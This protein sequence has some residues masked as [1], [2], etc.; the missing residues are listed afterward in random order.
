MIYF[1]ACSCVGCRKSFVR[2]SSALA[3]TQYGISWCTIQRTLFCWART[4]DFT[5]IKWFQTLEVFLTAVSMITIT[6]CRQR[7]M[8]F[9][10]WVYVSLFPKSGWEGQL[11]AILYLYFQR[12][13][14]TNVMW[15]DSSVL[16][17]QKFSFPFNSIQVGRWQNYVLT[18]ML[19]CM[20]ATKMVIFKLF[21]I[22]TVSSV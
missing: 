3:K 13:D 20:L 11:T 17:F 21:I 4:K 14:T 16:Y 22:K 18:W 7:H 2:N 6:S 1:L 9:V 15:S 5:T 12:E 19:Y 10:F 8:S